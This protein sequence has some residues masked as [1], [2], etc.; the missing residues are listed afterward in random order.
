MN[1]VYLYTNTI[2]TAVDFLF[3][4]AD[5]VLMSSVPGVQNE[6]DVWWSF[7]PL[8]A[9]G[10]YTVVGKSGS[11]IIGKEE[12]TWNG[13]EIVP[14]NKLIATAIREEFAQE[15]VHLIS[16]QNGLTEAQSIMLIELYRLMGLDPTRP[17]YVSRQT[18][19]VLPEI[20][21]TIEDNNIRTI[22]TRVT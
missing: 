20:R 11:K 9:A 21:Q 8:L 14:E 22:V 13:T 4:D 2:I 3:F 10:D 15:V 19:T 6:D 12:I 17:L 7:V 16:L 18:R 1:K 5:G